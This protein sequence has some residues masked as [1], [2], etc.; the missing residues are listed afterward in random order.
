MISPAVSAEPA[1]LDAAGVAAE[2]APGVVRDVVA[3]WICYRLLA[4]AAAVRQGPVGGAGAAGAARSRR[5]CWSVLHARPCCDPVKSVC[6]GIAV[7]VRS[8][9][10]RLLVTGPDWDESVGS[11]FCKT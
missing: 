7:V 6:L 9:L 4:L 5:L 3:A 8:E 2:A 1:V 11:E 10:E